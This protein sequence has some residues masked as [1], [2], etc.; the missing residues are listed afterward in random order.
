MVLPGPGLL[1]LFGGLAVLAQQYHWAHRW[2]GPVKK[3]AFR[4]AA[5][6][7]RTWPRVVLS[8]VGA[9]SLIAVGVLWWAQ[10]PE[11]PWWPLAE[12]W[13]LIGGWGTGVSLVGSGLIAL[14]LLVY[15]V[16]R[17]R[18]TPPVRVPAPRVVSARPA[19]HRGRDRR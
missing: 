19:A 1:L 10:P 6:G 12:R 2:L 9:L 7:V 15:S 13:W 16:H 8:C 11:P 18:G 4:A 14:A 3:Q 17:F 5:E